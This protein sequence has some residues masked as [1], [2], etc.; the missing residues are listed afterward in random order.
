VKKSASPPLI[1]VVVESCLLCELTPQGWPLGL[2]AV[3]AGEFQTVKTYDNILHDTRS[4]RGFLEMLAT[5]RRIYE[6]LAERDDPSLQSV[7][8]DFLRVASMTYP[9]MSLLSLVDVPLAEF[10]HL[11]E[12]HE[13]KTLEEDEESIL[14]D[15]EWV[16]GEGN[17]RFSVRDLKTSTDRSSPLVVS[18]S[19]K[20][21]LNRLLGDSLVPEKGGSADEQAMMFRLDPTELTE[22]RFLSRVRSELGRVI[23]KPDLR[24][25]G[26]NLSRL[27]LSDGSAARIYSLS[28]SGSVELH[29]DH[30]LIQ[31]A[32]AQREEDPALLLL[33]VSVLFTAINAATAQLCDQEELDLQSA[34]A[35]YF[36]TAPARLQSRS[37]GEPRGAFLGLDRFGVCS[38]WADDPG[39]LG[40]RFYFQKP[41]PKVE[42]DSIVPLETPREEGGFHFEF[43][44]PPTA[45]DG[46]RRLIHA[47]L[48]HPEDGHL[49]E[50]DGSPRAYAE[51]HAKPA[52]PVGKIVEVTDDGECRGWC[53]DPNDPQGSPQVEFYLDGDWKTGEWL[54]YSKANLPNE[55]V[56]ELTGFRGD[57][58]F[59]FKIPSQYRDGCKHTLCAYGFDLE[60]TA[61][62]PLLEGSPHDFI[63]VARH[64][65][66][67]DA[68]GR[69]RE[70]L[71][72]GDFETAVQELKT[73]LKKGGDQVPDDEVWSW[74]G[75]AHSAL[76]QHR[77]ADVAYTEAIK[78]APWQSEHWYFSGLV[79]VKRN[80]VRI[81]LDRFRKA[82]EKDSDNLDARFELARL[83]DS[84][85]EAVSH[86]ETLLEKKGFI[87]Y[88]EA[89]S[90]LLNLY[91]E[92]GQGKKAAE[93]LKNAEEH[94]VGGLAEFARR[95]TEHSGPQDSL[96]EQPS[97]V[98]HSAVQQENRLF[99]Q[100]RELVDN[101][102]FDKALALLKGLVT[103]G[104]FDGSL[105][106]L[107]GEVGR[108]NEGLGRFDAARK[109]YQKAL[110]YEPQDV[111]LWCA[112]GKMWE[113]LEDSEN[114]KQAFQEAVNARP[115]SSLAHFA[116]GDFLTRTGEEE[117]GVYALEQCLQ[118]DTEGRFQELKERLK[119]RL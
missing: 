72:S 34:L 43:E 33:L 40:V 85:D 75:A 108:A 59:Q 109:A 37:A 57:H 26:F 1:R 44:L 110:T 83:T 56:E 93:L 118:L 28:S 61:G 19:Q 24:L 64:L 87:R 17:Q 80:Q 90:A 92:K 22:E 74:L 2:E 35:D 99:H 69:G 113:R 49:V 119:A 8:A 12:E 51:P 89:Y 25:G 70:A 114:A 42:P 11:V 41:G 38:G 20:N 101:E 9:V 50:L 84:F 46:E 4:V 14:L 47:C 78:L 32:L 86:W 27:T 7:L 30:P 68:W 62:N 10:S 73:R 105:H 112:L 116:L 13:W 71:E 60:S 103:R 97:D 6:A 63:L 21:T 111:H 36:V 5:V 29:R 77:E 65:E 106:E 58:G 95:V 53:V 54:G 104:R 82:L 16:K 66:G 102:E 107:W 79:K 100:A 18:D 3:I 117:E 98:A 52:K 45:R 67:N 94:G 76:E 115:D 96:P 88:G 39:G 55:A 48:I 15:V 23:K 91:L 81:A 31:K